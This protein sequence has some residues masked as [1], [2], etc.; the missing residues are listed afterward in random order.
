MAFVPF[1]NLQ[2]QGYKVEVHKRADTSSVNYT[3]SKGEFK[4]NC[5]EPDYNNAP[6]YYMELEAHVIH[7][8]QDSAERKIKEMASMYGVHPGALSQMNMGQ[9][10]NDRDDAKR[11]YAMMDKRAPWEEE[12]IQ[13]EKRAAEEAVKKK[14]YNKKLLVVIKHKQRIA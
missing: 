4:Y 5:T 7:A 9:M 12:A 3:I 10:Y 13:K 2:K 1:D 11:Y 8:F 14:K 6:R